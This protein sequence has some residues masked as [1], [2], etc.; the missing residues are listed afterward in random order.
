MK[1]MVKRIISSIMAAIL[2]ILTVNVNVSSLYANETTDMGASEKI[3]TE[4]IVDNGDIE[5]DTI[6]NAWSTLYEYYLANEYIAEENDEL[7]ILTNIEINDNGSIVFSAQKDT[8]ILTLELKNDSDKC[9][10]VFTNQIDKE[11]VELS[12]EQS[13]EEF[14]TTILFENNS[15]L[16]ED[17]FS[18]MSNDAEDILCNAILLWADILG[19]CDLC[20]GDLGFEDWNTI[21]LENETNIS[22]ELD[23][24]STEDKEVKVALEDSAD[25]EDIFSVDDKGEASENDGLTQIDEDYIENENTEIVEEI[26]SEIVLGSEFDDEKICEDAFTEELQETVEEEELFAT[27]APVNDVERIATNYKSVELKVG[28]TL[29]LIANY[30]P[31]NADAL[32]EWSCPDDLGKEYI[33]VD[34]VTGL[35]KAKKATSGYI[36]IK[37]EDTNSGICTY[38]E[39]AVSENNLDYNTDEKGN[40]TVDS[41]NVVI[42][43]GIWVGGY[44]EDD[45]VYTGQ[46]VKQNI[47]VYY[48]GE[49]LTLNKDYSLTY[50]NNINACNSKALNAA[51]VTVTMKGQYSGKKTLY[52]GIKQ[53]DISG[54]TNDTDN[55]ALIYNGKVQKYVPTLT[56][57]GKKLVNNKDFTIEYNGEIGEEYKGDSLV[58][59]EYGYT[60]T[61]K[62]NFTGT[63]NG[64]YFITPKNENVSKAAVTLASTMKYD[65]TPITTSS[66]N[67]KIKMPGET[68]YVDPLQDSSKYE[69][70]LN[71]VNPTSGTAKVTI[72]GVG[73]GAT[74]SITKS[75]KVVAAYNIAKTTELNSTFVSEK[76]FYRNIEF[77]KQNEENL[78]INKITGDVLQKGVDYE[79]TVSYSNINK[80]GT[81]KITIKGKGAY[82]GS[83]SKSY[84]L[85]KSDFDLVASCDNEVDFVQGGA[86]NNFVVIN[87][88]DQGDGS[89]YEDVLTENVDYS[90]NYKYIDAVGIDTA[91]ATIVPKGSYKGAP[92]IVKTYTIN[93]V[94]ISDCT[95]SVPDKAYSGKANSYKSTPVITA[96]N[97]KKLVAGKDYSKTIAYLYENCDEDFNPEAGTII[98]VKIEGIGNYKGIATGSYRLYDSKISG[99]NKLYFAVD[100]QIYT[101][102][103]IEPNLS[104]IHIYKTANDLKNKTSEIEENKQDYIRIISYK[105]NIK[106]GTGTIT[107]GGSYSENSKNYG[108]TRNISFKIVKKNYESSY[109]KAIALD[110]EKLTLTSTSEKAI[111][112]LSAVFTP[113][114]VD[115]E[116]LVWKS[117]NSNIISVSSTSGKNAYVKAEAVGTAVITCTTQDGNKVAKCTV[118]SIMKPVTGIQLNKS[119]IALDVGEESQSLS[120]SAIPVDAY[121]ADVDMSA[122]IMESS[123]VNVAT[124]DSNGVVKAVGKGT[125]TITA[126]LNGMEATVFVVV[127]ASVINVKDEGA[128]GDGI[129]NDAY[130]IDKAIR[131]STGSDSIVYIPKGIYAINLEY[132]SGINIYGKSNLTL[133]MDPEAVL[134]NVKDTAKDTMRGIIR[135]Q[136][137]SNITIEGGLIDCDKEKKSVDENY[138]G[139]MIGYSSDI[140]INNVK[141]IDS[142]G[143][144]IYIG[145][146]NVTEGC[147]NKNI[148]ISKCTIENSLRNNI[149]LVNVIGASIEDCNIN[150]AIGYYMPGVS[151]KVGGTG[152]DV[153]P[154]SKN[155]DYSQNQYAQNITIK[156]CVFKDNRSDFGIHCH[157][158]KLC[159]YTKDIILDGCSFDKL[160]YIQCGKNIEFKN[161][162]RKPNVYYE[163]GGGRWTTTFR[164]KLLK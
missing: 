6:I 46:A 134:L 129:T 113:V 123:D 110:K 161:T 4:Q 43:D 149:S 60:I 18:Q 55:I 3:E 92:N 51:S 32:I 128:V 132:G 15:N 94:N 65:G 103:Q 106:A 136:N 69:V 48:K 80:V 35:L 10:V 39:V 29:Q 58:S 158:T 22:Y 67:L 159:D 31:E 72:K 117:S 16:T 87:R 13:I 119:L 8:S 91:V 52:Y 104:S 147:Y 130:A 11:A 20:W 45:L 86:K 98:T 96:P 81:A 135:I 54:V 155:E 21:C 34:A 153:E 146:G 30:F 44:Q 162:V 56:L 7:T 26:C 78:L 77:N 131:K 82:S 83:V 138:F 137:S 74:G 95:V 9:R 71:P 79:E 19:K 139:I 66:L 14:G 105:N 124:V 47:V 89:V 40:L 109:V 143:D 24:E 151:Y 76:K 23:K 38:I 140:V 116:T 100:D 114:D 112:V 37:V 28:D 118:S 108:G 49:A 125:A 68:A 141:I 133:I 102:K 2:V 64:T 115:N 36:R 154:N 57:N 152:I 142:S 33:D 97:G 163:D 121:S 1:I 148:S 111:G 62:G 107:I 27:P 157:Y 122:K 50:K 85:V 53:A 164:D 73:N 99:I 144:G 145:H 17:S 12:T 88:V 127:G 150:N 61:G 70:T 126:S 101:G 90:V 84:K 5:T 41:N 42:A 25:L 160:I 120:I 93:K 156:N 63:I 75:F 59:R